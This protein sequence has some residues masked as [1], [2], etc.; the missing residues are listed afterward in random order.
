MFTVAPSF[1]SAVAR[2]GKY[3]VRRQI[4]LLSDVQ[5]TTPFY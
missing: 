3:A 5:L 2:T 1:R 4:V